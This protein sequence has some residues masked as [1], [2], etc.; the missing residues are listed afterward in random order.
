MRAGVP[1]TFVCKSK[2]GRPKPTLTWRIGSAEYQ[3]SE[4]TV[5]DEHGTQSVTNTLVV[6]L[7]PADHNKVIYCD[8]TY[9]YATRTKVDKQVLIVECKFCGQCFIYCAFYLF[10]CAF[11]LF[12]YVCILLIYLFVQFYLFICAIYLFICAILFIYLCIL[13]IY[14]CILFIYLCILFIYLCI[15]LIYLFVQFYLFICAFYLFNCAFYLFIYFKLI[16][17]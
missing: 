2:R 6:T 4:K 17:F 1:A 13:F 9:I 3:G 11:Y 16:N 7:R 10:I 5:D 8:S 14:L 15:L 12:I